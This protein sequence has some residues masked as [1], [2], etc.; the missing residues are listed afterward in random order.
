MVFFFLLLV[1]G[2]ETLPVN[3]VESQQNNDAG[4]LWIDLRLGPPLIPIYNESAR[5]ADI[6]RVDHPNQIGQLRQIENGRKMVIFK[7]VEETQQLLPDIANEIDI[8]GYNLE[9]TPGTPQSDQADPLGSVEV[10]RALADEYDLQ[11]AL[12]PDHDFVLSHGVELA[13]LVDIFVLQIQRQ[14]TDPRT[15]AAYVEPTVPLLREANPDLEISVQV[16]TEGDV[17][18]LVELI[19]S[20]DADLDGVSILTSPDTVDVAEEL[21][22][23]LRPGGAVNIQ[24]LAQNPIFIIAA[25][26]ILLLLIVGAYRR[27]RIAREKKNN[28]S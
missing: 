16:R 11:L 21:V 27:G 5:S 12:G 15:V 3:A 13:P 28:D 7:S 6:A 9:H 24:E 25:V 8:I 23:A 2:A 22:A 14:Q 18:E 10:M 20:L 1:D 19:E 17:Q 26:A 4:D